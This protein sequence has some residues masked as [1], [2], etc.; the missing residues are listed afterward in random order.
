M[1]FATIASLIEVF[2]DVKETNQHCGF[3]RVR[4]VR[5]FGDVLK[6]EKFEAKDI[7]LFASLIPN[8]ECDA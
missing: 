5:C 7:I 4:T 3:E 1:C 2:L 6:V 8:R